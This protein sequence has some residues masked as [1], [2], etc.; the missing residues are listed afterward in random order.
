MHLHKFSGANGE[1]T[2]EVWR[3]SRTDVC[4]CVCACV[5]VCVCEL[6]RLDGHFGINQL[7]AVHFTH[8]FCVL[9]LE[10]LTLPCT[11]CEP[12]HNTEA[13]INVHTVGFG[14]VLYVSGH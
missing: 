2:G 9:S 3:P 1:A 14:I 8:Q 13:E 6:T 4:V 10:M 12:L 7:S 5:C 11:I